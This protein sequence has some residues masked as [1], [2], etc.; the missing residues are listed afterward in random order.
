MVCPASFGSLVSQAL[1]SQ[2]NFHC[3]RLAGRLPAVQSKTPPAWDKLVAA[4]N[5]IR[6]VVATGCCAVAGCNR[7][8]AALK[9]RLAPRPFTSLQL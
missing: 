1:R 5:S 6:L 7:G 8:P 9:P 3:K 2:H 4:N